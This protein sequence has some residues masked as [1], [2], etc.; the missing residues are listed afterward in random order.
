MSHD[1]IHNHAHEHCHGHCGEHAHEHHHH[2][3][4]GELRETIVKLVLSAILLVVAIVIEKNTDLKTWQYLLIY[5]IPYLIVGWETLKEG[6]GKLLEGE[7]LDEDFLMGVATVGAL[8][9]GFL[10][11]A[12]NQFPEAVFVML[13]FQLGELFEG[14]AEGRSRRSISALMDIRPDTANLETPEGLKVVRPD[15]VAVG[16]TVV[17]KPGE[18]VPMDGVV[19]EGNSAL[20]TKALTGESVPRNISA[21]DSIISGCINLWGLLRVKVGKPFGESTASRVLELVENA[22]G[23]KS[24]SE[25]FI[26]RFAKIYTPIVVGAAVLLAIIPPLAGGGSFATWLYRALTFLIVSCPCALVISVPLSFFGGIGGASRRGILVKGANYLEALTRLGTVVF[27]KTGTLTEGVFEV[28]AVH[29]EIIKEKELLHLTAHVER[30]SKHPVAE[31]LRKAYPEEADDCNVEDVREFA[32]KGVQATVNGRRIS[33]GNEKMMEELGIKVHG[34][35]KCGGAGTIVHVAVDS[36]YVGH[37]LIS[38]RVKSSSAEAI[39][40]LKAAGAGRTVMLTGDSAKV[41]ESVA[42]TVGVDSYGAGLLPAEKLS[43]LETLIDTADKKTTVAFVG[44]GI[45][46]APV[47]A[48]A[49]IGIAMGAL[50][51]DAAIEAADVVLMDDDPRKIATAIR[52]ARKTV[53][54]SRQNICFAITVKLAVLLLAAFGLAPMWL[55][56]FADVGVTV[57]AV[58]NAMRTLA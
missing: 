33:A 42:K 3:E 6:A 25:S 12:G 23:N 13:F 40:M 22:A 56:V 55:A 36:E 58:L 19:L 45:N 47:L 8:A 34:C 15:S 39:A 50:G 37:I 10:P 7:A 17:V 20:D 11:G 9:I 29:P 26:T 44:D 2:N 54:I 18:K 57:I 43:E 38:D 21:G 51:S 27:D 53:G 16:E 30:H 48:R 52:I 28:T 1:H 41:A 14:I 46:D 35:E 31:A 49:D 32:G 5:L 4:E 24:R